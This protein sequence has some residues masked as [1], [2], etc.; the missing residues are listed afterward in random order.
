MNIAKLCEGWRKRTSDT[1]NLEVV[2]D[3]QFAA[4]HANVWEYH[5]MSLSLLP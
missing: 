2:Y 4:M 3:M 1:H 5:S